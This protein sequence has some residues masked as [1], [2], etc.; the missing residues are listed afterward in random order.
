MHA[1]KEFAQVNFQEKLK[2][3]IIKT[4]IYKIY[5]ISKRHA[6]L[7]DYKS[8]MKCFRIY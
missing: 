6:L 4:L 5:Y 1:L 3:L 7:R 2:I 8:M